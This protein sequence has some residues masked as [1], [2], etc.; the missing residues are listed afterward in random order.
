M[1]SRSALLAIAITRP[2][3]PLFADTIAK[4]RVWVTD[5]STP[6]DVCCYVQSKN[7]TG[8]R[9]TSAVVCS[10]GNQAGV[11]QL[12]L[13]TIRDGASWSQASVVCSMPPVTASGT[14][15]LHSYRTQLADR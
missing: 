11:Q 3:S 7:P 4:T 10:S 14:S 13:P 8:T 9:V 15:G 2:V 1:V 5:R 12:D 6:D